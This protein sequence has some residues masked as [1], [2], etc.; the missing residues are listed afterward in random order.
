[1]ASEFEIALGLVAP[2]YNL[3]LAAIAF[4]LFIRMFH[5]PNRLVYMR[6]WKVLFAAFCIYLV[7]EGF[8]ALRILGIADLPRVLNG[9]FEMVII[10]LFIYMLFLQKEYVAK[11]IK[12]IHTKMPPPEI[13]EK[14]RGKKKR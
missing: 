12:V 4:Y 10:G 8:T 5:L 7:E 9:V 11:S 3:V 13:V 14:S 6:P 2:F 1:M